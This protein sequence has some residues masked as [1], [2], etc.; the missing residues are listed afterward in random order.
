M[1][2]GL[3]LGLGLM[4]WTRLGPG[5][6]LVGAGNEVGTDA[7]AVAEASL[8]WGQGWGWG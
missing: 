2:L 8:G 4:L 6:R 7:G 1:R 5:L 3:V